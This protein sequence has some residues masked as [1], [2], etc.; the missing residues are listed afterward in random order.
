MCPSQRLPMYPTGNPGHPTLVY[1]DAMLLTSELLSLEHGSRLLAGHGRLVKGLVKVGVELLS[2]R[3][4]RD[5]S[6][7]RQNLLDRGLGE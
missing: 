3:V 1:E 4:E 2:R 5:N 7:P 6:V